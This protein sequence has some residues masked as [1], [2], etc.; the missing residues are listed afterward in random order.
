MLQVVLFVLVGWLVYR[1]LAP[2]LTQLSREDLLRY[3]PSVPLLI[4]STALITSIN[5]MHALIWRSITVA[6]TGTSVSIRSAMR[7]FFISSLGRYVPGK[8]WQLAS[9]AVL[10]QAEGISAVGAT[11][12]SLV[13]QLAF[14]TTGILFL[15]V[16]LPS[17]LSG[18]AV[19]AA[20]GLIA[21]A[22]VLMVFAFSDSGKAVRQRWFSRVDPRVAQ[23]GAL[24]DRLSLSHALQ[25]WALY[26][27]S[28]VLVGVAFNLFV[29]AFVPE[30]NFVDFAA[31]VAASYV[32]GYISLLP[33]GVGVRE[34][35]MAS[36]L[37]PAI[38]AP[39]AL[40]ISI[41][42]RLWFSAGE[43]LP[44]MAVPFFP[45]TGRAA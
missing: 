41:M 1:Q 5:V 13:G 31:V 23:A 4:A 42:S 18:A 25:Y 17:V 45:R 20:V 26:A 43:L 8:V 29:T 40:L 6:L 32:G 44:L 36:L 34:G 39:A 7:V 38:G 11:A 9:M 21:A 19:W 16:L 35:V 37:T 27:F 10:A 14:L 15:A 2:Q 33:A 12:A 3:R 24:L 22:L 28:W 30:R